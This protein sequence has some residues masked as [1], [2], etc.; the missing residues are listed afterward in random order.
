MYKVAQEGKKA[1]RQF[2]ALAS[3]IN[4]DSFVAMARNEKGEK[5]TTG[6]KPCFNRLF[7]NTKKKV[8]E[9]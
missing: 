3:Q 2:W 5:A 8:N 4:F 1:G 6:E 7:L 9:S